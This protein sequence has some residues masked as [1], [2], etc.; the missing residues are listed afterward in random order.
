MAAEQGEGIALSRWSLVSR[1]I[2]AGRLVR[3]VEEVVKADW[4]HYF[5]APPQYFDL[6]KVADFRDWMVV[7]CDNFKPPE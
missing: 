1:D 7:Q 3:P 5:V 6:P 2:N 4:S